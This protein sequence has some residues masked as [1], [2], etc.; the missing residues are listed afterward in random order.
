MTST[1]VTRTQL[2][3]FFFLSVNKNY[4]VSRMNQ[5]KI[6]NETKSKLGLRINKNCTDK[7]ALRTCE[8]RVENAKYWGATISTPCT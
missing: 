2:I 1:W 6:T 5:S 8:N 4:D 3:S 7:F